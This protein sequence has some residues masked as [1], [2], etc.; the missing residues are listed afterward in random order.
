MDSSSSSQ[1]SL[2]RISSASNATNNKKSST[3]SSHTRQSRSSKN[4]TA[5]AGG[6]SLSATFP[7]PTAQALKRLTAG[8]NATTSRSSGSAH[9]KHQQP[10]QPL[11]SN[12]NDGYTGVG[13]G[14]CAGNSAAASLKL[15]VS[16]I[17]LQPPIAAQTPE[18]GMPSMR[19]ER[20]YSS[21]KVRTIDNVDDCGC[22]SCACGVPYVVSRNPRARQ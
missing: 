14:E 19:Q 18:A 20:P 9:Q 4:A 15:S 3:T 7:R 11:H 16:M 12:A 8:A 2:E 21:L 5:A 22:F 10:S 17:S 6:A 13:G 1:P